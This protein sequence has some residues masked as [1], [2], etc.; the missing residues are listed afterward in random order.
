MVLY[1]YRTFYYHWTLNNY[2]SVMV[3]M[4]AWRNWSCMMVMMWGIMMMMTCLCHVM[5]IVMTVIMTYLYP[6][7]SSVMMTI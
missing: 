5:M 2:R 3:M 1:N 6:I 4:M 7:M